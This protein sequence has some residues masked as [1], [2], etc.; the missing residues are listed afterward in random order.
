MKTQENK[1]ISSIVQSLTKEA[2]FVIGI[3][4]L[5]HQ[6]YTS[7]MNKKGHINCKTAEELKAFC[8]KY[9]KEVLIFT[10]NDELVHMG[11][12]RTANYLFAV[13]IFPAK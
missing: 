6:Q 8:S 4:S 13:C 12:K 1:F 7:D 2:T 10:M 9:F 11:F 5:E 3:P